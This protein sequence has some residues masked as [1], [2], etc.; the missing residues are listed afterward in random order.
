MYTS[1]SDTQAPP[2]DAR[3]A[4]DVK[5]ALQALVSKLQSQ[6][7]T[8]TS[9]AQTMQQSWTGPYADQFFGTEV[10]RMAKQTADLIGELQTWIS[11]LD[12]ATSGR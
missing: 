4:G 12:Q 10:A 8:R 5:A 3:L 11:I 1:G 6:Q 7:T 2:V 9:R